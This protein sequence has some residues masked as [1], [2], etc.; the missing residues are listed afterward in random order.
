M[1][2]YDSKLTKEEQ[3][4]VRSFIDM[5]ATEEALPWWFKWKLGQKDNIEFNFIQFSVIN[6]MVDVLLIHDIIKETATKSIL[7]KIKKKLDDMK[8]NY[9]FDKSTDFRNFVE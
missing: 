7:V 4:W 5:F 3:V 6:T 8:V 1:W 9:D 2:V